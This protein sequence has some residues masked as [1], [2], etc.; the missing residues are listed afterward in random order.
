M[1]NKIKFNYVVEEFELSDG[2]QTFLGILPHIT[3]KQLRENLPQIR[4][5]INTAKTEI[6][7][8][9][10]YTTI[11]IIPDNENKTKKNNKK[12]KFNQI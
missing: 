9:D 8:F 11:R 3:K 10:I 12:R 7:K 5:C 2:K 1:E 4:N 6:G